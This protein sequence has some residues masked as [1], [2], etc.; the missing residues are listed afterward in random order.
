MKKVISLVLLFSL[1]VSLAA[2]SGEGS[3]N[4]DTERP[5]TQQ[6]ILP[7]DT[8]APDV[9][10]DF[11]EY[12]GRTV[13]ILTQNENSFEHRWVVNE[14]CVD[15]LTGDQVNDAVY[16]RN[17]EVEKLL[18]VKIEETIQN[19]SDKL[20]ESVNSGDSV[21]DIVAASSDR[22]ISLVY[23]G[24]V[25]N[26]YGNG[27]ERYLNTESPWWAQ[28]WIDEAEING[29]LYAITGDV[30]LSL[31]RF[32]M[33]MFY[34][35]TMAKS[36]NLENPYE[37]VSSGRWTIDYVNEIISGVYVDVDGDKTVNGLDRFGIAL[38]TD[39][40]CDMFWS[41]FDMSLFAKGEDGWYEYDSDGKEKLAAAFDKVYTL[42]YECPDSYNAVNRAGLDEDMRDMFSL[43]NLLLAPMHLKY[44]ES[45]HFRLMRD[46]YTVL[47]LP[48]YD[49]AQEDYYTFV[50][51]QYS[52]FMVPQNASDPQLSGVLLEAM[53]AQSYKTLRPTYY[54][55][56]LKGKYTRDEET[57]Q[58]VDM[59]M[60]N[61]K[62][63]ASFI[64]GSVSFNMGKKVFSELFGEKNKNFETKFSTYERLIPIVLGDFKKEFEDRAAD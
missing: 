9:G 51:E 2:C 24:L 57:R 33:V 43:G 19:N 8:E 10:L 11:P 6:G 13:N 64:Y 20:R 30:S 28:H 17:A 29:Q 55:S 49:E 31:S 34:N 21:Y 60:S 4:R 61:V 16:Y 7:N 52:I 15:E 46:K 3:E 58:I 25:Q 36:L 45:Q 26:L 48:K 12:G 56:V 63:D 1:L 59:V 18:G 44:G 37:V 22:S 32:A 40:N 23:N 47:P 62:L 53:A 50:Q 14:I 5:D 54:D 27:I 42:I 38:T 35:K 39:D 41:A